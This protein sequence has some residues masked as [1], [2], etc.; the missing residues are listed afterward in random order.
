M[1]GH[2]RCRCRCHCCCLCLCLY[3][4]LYLYLC[5]CRF[6]VY[7]LA[8]SLHR[9]P[10]LSLLLAL[11]AGETLRWWSSRLFLARATSRPSSP[12]SFS[13]F[14]QLGLYTLRI[15]SLQDR[16]GGARQNAHPSRGRVCFASLLLLTPHSDITS[17]RDPKQFA[18][19]GE[20]FKNGNYCW[21]VLLLLGKWLGNLR[22]MSWPSL[23]S[24]ISSLT[25]SSLR[26]TV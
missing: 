2:C 25:M 5:F 19:V 24:S 4:Y 11:F 15:S 3:L 13:L 6:L 1:P 14:R 8:E 16:P 7:T 17:D 10:C 21:P 18:M 12:L 9:L 20:R 23:L 22:L 26:D